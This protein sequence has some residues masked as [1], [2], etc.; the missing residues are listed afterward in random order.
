MAFLLNALKL[1]TRPVLPSAPVGCAGLPI[2]R[3]LIYQMGLFS[4]NQA[5]PSIL[6]L[7][8]RELKVRSAVK[9][10]CSSCQVRESTNLNV[11]RAK[12]NCSSQIF[13][14]FCY[15]NSIILN[16]FL[17]CASERPASRDLQSAAATQAAP[18]MTFSF[19]IHRIGDVS[20]RYLLLNLDLYF[21]LCVPY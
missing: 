7:T 18:G 19:P 5:A 11:S 14:F 2:Y 12:Y 15:L 20:S 13:R 16:N 8:I 9:K 6:S 3:V 10:F 17:V 4:Q 1:F 21:L